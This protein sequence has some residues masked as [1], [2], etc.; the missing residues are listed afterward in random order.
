MW[1]MGFIGR[2]RVNG[3][4]DKGFVKSYLRWMNKGLIRKG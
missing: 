4:N 3:E 1:L 2:L